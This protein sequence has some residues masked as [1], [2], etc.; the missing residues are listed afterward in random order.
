MPLRLFR[1]PVEICDELLLVRGRKLCAVGHHFCDHSAPL[2]RSLFRGC[3][4][5]VVALLT[6][7]LKYGFALAFRHLLVVPCRSACVRRSVGR[8]AIASGI[9]SKKRSHSLDLV[10]HYLGSPSNHGVDRVLPLFRGLP[11]DL[12]HPQDVGMAGDAYLPDHFSALLDL[13]LL[14]ALRPHCFLSLKLAAEMRGSSPHQNIA[15]RQR[16][17]FLTPGPHIQ[18]TSVAALVYFCRT[19]F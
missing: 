7:P 18:S 5:Q 14:A 6:S 8:L 16:E 4:C 11:M 10:R 17:D 12:N 1:E 13:S 3:R 9:R 15:N 2:L 19:N